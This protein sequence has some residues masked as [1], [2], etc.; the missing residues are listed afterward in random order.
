MRGP[1]PPTQI[2]GPPGRNGRGCSSRPGSSFRHNRRARSTALTMALTLRSLATPSAFSSA[3]VPGSSAPGPMPTIIRPLAIRSRVASE[4]A[5]ERGL[6]RSGSRTAVPSETRV[7]APATPARRVRGSP[8][9]RASRESPAHTESK[10]AFSAC[11]AASI[12]KA[13]SLSAHSRASRDGSRSPVS[14]GC[15]SVVRRYLGSIFTAKVWTAIFPSL[16]MK[17]S[18]PKTMSADAHFACQMMYATSPST[19]RAS[20]VSS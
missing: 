7:V 20:N 16:T 2:G 17:V 13:R 15:I 10:P 3:C 9:G 1:V 4:C 12:R 8:R 18:V 6:R 11:R 19:R 14:C 5:R